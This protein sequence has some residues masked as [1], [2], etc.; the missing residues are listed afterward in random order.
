MAKKSL[1]IVESPTKIKTIGKFLG[2]E[3]VI[4]ASVGHVK[5]L[6]SKELGVD[7]ENDFAPKYVTIRGKAKVLT[8]IKKA[9]ATAE[10]IYLAPDPDREG[11]AICWHLAQELKKHKDKI[12]R[13]FFNEITKSAVLEALQHPTRINQD[14]FNAQQARRILDR[15]VGYKLSPL[16]WRKVQRGLSAGRVQSVAVRLVC[17]REEEIKAFKPQEYW[18]GTAKLEGGNRPPF[19]AKLAKLKGKKVVLGSQEQTQAVLKQLEGQE[20]RVLDI[21]TKPKKRNPVPPFIT[22]KLQ[23]EAAR[24]L[25][26][27][28]KKTMMVAQ[29]LYEGINLGKGEVGLIT[30][31]RTDSTRISREA[32][33]EARQYIAK[34]FG[35]EYLPAKAINYKSK[36]GA[37]DAH[38]A[39]R[40]TSVLRTPDSLK[41]RLSRDHLRL[42]GL[43]W[44]RLV[45]SQMKPALL[46]TT[47]VEIQAG[48]CLF[49]ANGLVVKFLGFTRVY[50][51]GK[52]EE[53][54]RDE[55]KKLPPLKREEVLS[56]I[57][58]IF[59][60]GIFLAQYKQYIENI[61]YFRVK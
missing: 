10:K 17:E 59:F 41:S 52:D 11:E 48:S 36:K 31:M 27:S 25:G 21:K 32:Q 22:S 1:I 43:I 19:E 9:A 13:L 20:Y 4:K 37:Q 54:E 45:A 18:S 30:Y 7:V 51:E 5:D 8:E 6:P 39:I 46:D 33:G 40:P 38:E 56:F 55:S 15:L 3:Y 24:K 61:T 58:N 35:Q 23:Q 34:T 14:L 44:Q 2:P 57:S 26:F 29:Q 60:S 42:Y 50:V 47:Q 12:S 49:Y 53:A 16:L 28:A